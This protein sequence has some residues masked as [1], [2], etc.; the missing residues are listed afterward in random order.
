MNAGVRFDNYKSSFPDQIK[1]ASIWQPEDFFI[2]GQTAVSWQDLQPR[3]GA[4]YDLFGDGRTA[5]KFSA[6]RAGQRD[7][8]DWALALHPGNN[9]V[10]Q[11]RSWND[12]LTGCLDANCIP[13]DGLPQGDPLNPLPNGELLTPNTNP[14]F[15][16]PITTTFFD[17]N[18]RE[19]WGNRLSNWEIT[20]SVQQELA[21]GVSLDIG[22]FRRAFVNL[23]A[24]NDRAVGP[25]D[26]DS[27]Q[28]QIPDDPRLPTAGQ[29]ITLVDL[30]P[31]S[32]L[33]PDQVTTHADNFGGE[34]RTWQGVDIT[35]DARLQGFLF[36]GGLSTGSW[37]TDRCAQLTALPEN[38]PNSAGNTV[39]API[40]FCKTSENWLTQVKFLAAY[41]LPYDVQVA[42][43]LQN[44][45]GPERIANVTYPDAVIS[46]ALGRPSTLGNQTVNV[47]EPGTV[48]GGAVLRSS[49]SGSRNFLVPQKRCEC[50][51]C[52]T[53]LTCSMRMRSLGNRP[54]SERA[55]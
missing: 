4:A 38:L 52:W 35:A 11:T 27:F 16:Q 50:G 37:S 54:V 3:L 40:D 15:G 10:S 13:G 5:L 6:N 23:W 28:V 25:E 39:R 24:Q 17:D 22:Y 53:S 51:R 42:A 32:I 1:K 14:A 29:M 41:T 31:E 43:T 18:W 48:F 8:T 49:T 36:Q 47:L 12:G 44:Q 9:N 19:G 26:F 21:S 46:A 7:A 30:K 33:I 2:E 34:S 55:G 20:A 45:A